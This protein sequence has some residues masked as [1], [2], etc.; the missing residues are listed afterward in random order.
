M[1]WQLKAVP[2]YWGFLTIKMVL[3]TNYNICALKC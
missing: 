2:R 1:R 3:S